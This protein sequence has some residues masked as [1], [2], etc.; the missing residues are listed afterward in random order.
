MTGLRLVYIYICITRFFTKLNDAVSFVDVLSAAVSFV[1]YFTTFSHLNDGLILWPCNG[2]RSR[3]YS[4]EFISRRSW[5]VK[6]ISYDLSGTV[7][8]SLKVLSK[9]SH[10]RQ[11]EFAKPEV[12]WHL[13]R[14]TSWSDVRGYAS[15]E[16][17][18]GS[19]IPPSAQSHRLYH[20]LQD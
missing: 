18:V 11:A 2:F 1:R 14:M 5:V 10:G 17:T 8:V 15:N 6:R 12:I 3:F 16:G 4:M 13:M 20:K 7:M 19:P 9:F